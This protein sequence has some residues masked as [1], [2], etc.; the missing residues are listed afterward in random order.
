[1][2]AAEIEHGNKRQPRLS[3]WLLAL[4]L[5]LKLS[6][7]AITER[8][9]FRMFAHAEVRLLSLIDR[10]LDGSEIRTAMRAIAEGL[11]GRLATGT[12]IVIPRLKIDC[13]WFFVGN[14]WF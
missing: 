13:H 10:E 8:W 5:V 1:M 7:R 12:P 11:V 3:I 9:V 4:L 2:E 14:S 6:M